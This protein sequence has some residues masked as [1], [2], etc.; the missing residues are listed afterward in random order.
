MNTSDGLKRTR[1][2]LIDNTELWI[3]LS[4][5]IKSPFNFNCESPSPQLKPS[6]NSCKR[7][8][9]LNQ[10][11]KIKCMKL[12]VKENLRYALP[13]VSALFKAS[14]TCVKW[15]VFKSQWSSCRQDRQLNWSLV[16]KYTMRSVK[17]PDLNI[18]HIQVM[19][20]FCASYAKIEVALNISNSDNKCTTHG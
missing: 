9:A 11:S 7:Q 12:R 3:H 1:W 20:C 17:S 19:V 6:R 16:L 5:L 10:T 18:L 15:I 2:F 8:D 4:I 13:T 14:C